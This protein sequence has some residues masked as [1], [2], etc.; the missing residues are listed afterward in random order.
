MRLGGWWRATC[1][2]AAVLLCS[3]MSS[4]PS[5]HSLT[6][7]WPSFLFDPGHSS[8]NRNATSI[9][10][11]SIPNLRHTWQWTE[12]LT[13]SDRVFHA[14][15]VVA[16]G[17]IYIG[18]ESG[19]FYA[20]SESTQ[21]VLWSR[22]FGVTPAAACGSIG[23]TST[24]TV[25]NDPSTGQ[26]VYVNAPDGYLYAL[27]AT[28]GATMWR[29]TVDTPSTTQDNY[30]AWSSPL[31]ANGH[32]Y[33]GIASECDDPLVPAGIVAF[34]QATGA[35]LGDW[36]SIPGGAIGASVWSTPA[37]STLNDGSI[38]VTTGN[39]SGTS[40][41]LYAESIVRLSG[42][43]LSLLDSWQVPLSQQVADADFGGSPTVFTADINGIS[44]PMVGA[45]NKNGIY[46]AFR[47]NDLHDGPVWQ[48][49]MAV[50]YG[51]LPN[52]GGQCDAAALWDGTHLIEGGGNS[53]VINGVTYQGSV[54]SLDPATGQP[55][56]QTGLPGE[57]IGSPTEDGA[58]IVAAQ[59]FQSN[60]GQYGIYLL[61]AS[62]GAI[63]DFIN[64]N[65]SPIFSQPVFTGNNLLVAGNAAIGL[66][67]YQVTM[68]GSPITS[69][70]PSAI[71]QGGTE[72][73]TLSGSNF[74][75][76]PSVWVSNTL[77]PAQSVTVLSSNSLQF[78]LTLSPKAQIGPQNIT[79]IE[80][81]PTSDSCS[82]CLTVDPAP[83]VST[84]TPGTIPQGETAS[85][86][87]TG[88]NFVAGAKIS[89]ASGISVSS[90][91]Y[92]SS[93]KLTANFFVK[94]SVTPGSYNVWVRNPDGGI[95][96]CQG[97]L[98]VT[99]D[100]A[101]TLA[102]VSP[103]AVGQQAKVSV[104]LTGTNLTTNAT[105]SFSASGITVDSLQYSS[106]TTLRAVVS[107]TRSAT[108]GAG[109]VTV[110]TPGGSATCKGCLTIDPH[111]I[112]GQISP[113]S[114][115]VGT[116]TVDVSGSQFISGLTVS[117]SIPGATLGAP[118]NVT[119]TFF[120]VAVTVPSGTTPGT[121][122][123]EVTNPDGG[124]GSALITVIN[125]SSRFRGDP[126]KL[127]ERAAGTR[128]Q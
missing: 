84:S 29:A 128:R 85:V 73:I 14:T 86:Q 120:S 71:G 42:N 33:V 57:V 72:T 24:A 38:F 95:G 11:S 37:E 30:Y 106:P 107:V 58:G 77:V 59:I 89:S 4:M 103:S 17:V 90:T 23:I 100:P 119:G 28:T 79:V 123:F 20:I 34:N 81:G 1:A 10:A 12:P 22:Y 46:Y 47:Q 35:L 53:T 83:T 99:A 82:G 44:T 45:C 6:V 104:T 121:Y 94:P 101:P 21:M 80:P 110:A 67:D 97:C 125:P 3:G 76:T 41:P 102:A 111:P 78:K 69:V 49:R 98:T 5:P 60:T 118:A 64:T 91:G 13:A 8:Y 127:G 16:N 55:I 108:L 62:T 124:T 115:E 117:T 19:N 96:V 39:A 105:L 50:P 52:P 7:G 18:S 92:V 112:V 51:T 56:W 54:Q 36:Q 70:T 75:G 88:S 32:I 114:I 87:V 31:V 26:T 27:N 116:T 93:N 40:Q 74:S 25:A 126:R 2:V 48:W 66:T 63:L 61:S 113:S 68:P 109:D 43:N 15:P 122:V 9:G 65:G